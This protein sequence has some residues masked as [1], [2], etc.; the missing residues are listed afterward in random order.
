MAYDAF[1]AIDQATQ[2]IEKLQQRFEELNRDL[3]MIGDHGFNQRN[4]KFY[5]NA[6][7]RGEIKISY[8]VPLAR[9]QPVYKAELDSQSNQIKLTRM[10]M[11]AQKTGEDWNNVKLT[12]STTQ[13]QKQVRQMSPKAWWVNYYEPEPA[14]SRQYA[15][16]EAAPAPSASMPMSIKKETSDVTGFPQFTTSDLN[17]STAFTADAQTSLASSRQEIYLPL[18][19]EQHPVKLSIW[20][21]PKQSTQAMINAELPAMSSQWPAG[22]V[23]LYRDGDFVGERVWKNN[24]NETL[25]MNFGYDDQIQIKVIDLLDKRNTLSNTQVQTVQK[26]QYQVQNLHAYPISL[27][28]FDSVPQ[29]QNSRLISQSQYSPT[30]T[31]TEWQGQ[32]NIN[33]WELQLAPKQKFELQLEHQFKYPSKG[34][35]SGF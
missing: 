4:L 13:P 27:T 8:V 20:A 6:A 33:L 19:T 22:M 26:Q 3:E 29:S 15:Y 5:V 24:Q 14:R 9:W 16:A 18:S 28:L 10:A 31:A 35:T 30:P 25:D 12:L 23:K 7:Q 2:R 32:P 17:F 1:L 21:I 34:R 11:I